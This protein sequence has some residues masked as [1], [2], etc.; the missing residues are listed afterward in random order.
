MI[1]KKC[2]RKI[3]WMVLIKTIQTLE[4]NIKLFGQSASLLKRVDVVT[5]R[6]TS[7]KT[8]ETLWSNKIQ[9]TTVPHYSTLF[10]YI[11]WVF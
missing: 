6:S 2:M 9:K 11:K 10:T 8:K 4:N 7:K 1:S 5:F 3:L